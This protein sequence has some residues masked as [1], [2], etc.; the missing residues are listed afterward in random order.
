MDAFVKSVNPLKQDTKKGCKRSLTRAHQQEAV[1][2]VAA[3]QRAEVG[4]GLAVGLQPGG[5]VE[6]PH[7]HVSPG[8]ARPVIRLR[9]ATST[10]HTTRHQ[11]WD[12]TVSLRWDPTVSLHWDPTVSLRWDATVS[13]HW[14]TTVSLAAGPPGAG[15][16]SQP[17]P[18]LYGCVTVRLL[19]SVLCGLAGDSPGAVLTRRYGPLRRATATVTAL[20]HWLCHCHAPAVDVL[21]ELHRVV[22]AYQPQNIRHLL[23]RRLC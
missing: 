19:C 20:C 4:H 5:D 14:D 1:D 3:Q 7:A 12:A 15:H 21:F 10:H 16:Q 8:G 11:N 6:Q 23:A 13:L 9:P 22:R 2:A 18:A 17:V